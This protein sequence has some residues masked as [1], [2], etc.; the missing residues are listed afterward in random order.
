MGL[1]SFSILCVPNF[2][3]NERASG[4]FLSMNC[5]I[6]VVIMCFLCEWC[7]FAVRQTSRGRFAILQNCFKVLHNIFRTVGCAFFSCN[8]LFTIYFID[9]TVSMIQYRK[10][11]EFSLESKT[12]HDH[13]FFWKI[14]SSL[15]FEGV[16]MIGTHEISRD[17]ISFLLQA[18]KG[19]FQWAV[20]RSINPAFRDWRGRNIWNTKCWTSPK[21][22][23]LIRN[24][25]I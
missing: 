11:C 9:E 7:P 8:V 23:I 20:G 1:K 5:V 13:F 17:Q 12:Q 22:F 14:T 2:L 10:V 6:K 19:R 18:W 4:I 16:C 21:S 24:A 3:Y 15:L 25:R